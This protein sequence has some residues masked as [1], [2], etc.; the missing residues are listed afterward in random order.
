VSSS[1]GTAFT[2]S[3]FV[4]ASNV[5][6]STACQVD[7]F[8]GCVVLFHFGWLECVE[9]RELHC[10]S[11]SVLSVCGVVCDDGVLVVD[12][13]RGERFAHSVCI[14][15]LIRMKSG[16]CISPKEH[17]RKE[18]VSMSSN[19]PFPSLIEHNER[20]CRIEQRKNGEPR[21]QLCSHQ[22]CVEARNRD[23]HNHQTSLENHSVN[24]HNVC[25]HG[26]LE[27]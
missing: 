6:A 2:Y 12:W 21:R 22:F 18:R 5:E 16:F 9:Q 10:E 7:V 3:N 23:K 27:H 1:N 17:L 24:H 26:M 4:V 14:V 13:W 20:S 15:D 11:G 19:V 8:C 25:Q